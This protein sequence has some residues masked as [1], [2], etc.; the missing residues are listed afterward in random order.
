[1]TTNTLPIFVNYN[2]DDSISASIKYEDGFINNQQMTWISKS[3]VNLD[4]NVMTL[5]REEETSHVQMYLFVRKTNSTLKLSETNTKTNKETAKEFYYLG[6]VHLEP[7]SQELITMKNDEGNDL[8]AV[9]MV[10]NLEHYVRD[11]IYDYLVN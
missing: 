11:D 6:K 4:N 1:M 9:K 3:K 5:M 7:Q 10:L 2:K 8:C